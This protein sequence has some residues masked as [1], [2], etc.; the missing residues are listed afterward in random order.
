MKPIEECVVIAMDG[1]DK[2][3]FRNYVKKQVF[4][5]DVL[6]NKVI[7]ITLFIKKQ[8]IPEMI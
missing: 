2:E 8:R 1:S 3:L 5:M 6:M 7:A 4:E